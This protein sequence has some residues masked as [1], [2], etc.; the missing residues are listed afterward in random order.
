[1]RNIFGGRYNI[2]RK[3]DLKAGH[4]LVVSPH[5]E[6]SSGLH[7]P[8]AGEREREEQGAPHP[9]GQRLP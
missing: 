4:D 5:V 6:Y 9:K 1:M 3:Y 7:R 8:E 2:H